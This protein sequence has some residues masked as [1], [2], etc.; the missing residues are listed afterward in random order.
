MNGDTTGLE[1]TDASSASDS[2]GRWRLAVQLFRQ[3]AETASLIGEWKLAREAEDAHHRAKA[4]VGRQEA[5]QQRGVDGED[6]Q[7]ARQGEEG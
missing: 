4:E 5:V 6:P 7:D 3:A 1:S 2:L